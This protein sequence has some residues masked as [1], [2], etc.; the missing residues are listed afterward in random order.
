MNDLAWKDGMN[1]SATNV[2]RGSE[3]AIM[4]PSEEETAPI[5][6]RVLLAEWANNNDEWIRLLVSEAITTGRPVDARVIEKVYQL[7]RQEK[8]LDNR[9]LP[10]VPK[11]S[12]QGHRDESAL[13]LILTKLSNV[14]GVN[15]LSVGAVIEPHEGLTI[16]YGE[17][18]TGK[19]GYARIFKALANSRTADTILGNIDADIVEAQSASLEFKLGNDTQSLTWNGER[20]ISPFTRMSIFDS[21]AVR[22]HV[23]ED[24]EYMY[25]PASLA[26]FDDVIDG[27]KA[28]LLKIDDAIT[29]LDTSVSGL[30]TRFHQG[31]SIYPLI[32]TL[33]PSTDLADLKSKIKA[34]KDDKDELESLTQKVAL[35]R[36]NTMTKHVT[37]LK[38]ENHVLEQALSAANKI[39]AFD[40][41][42]Y[43]DALVKH[44]QLMVDYETFRS[45]LF[46][47]VDLPAEPDDTWHKFVQA[48]ETY[49]QHLVS[50]EAE[51]AD[52]CLYCRQPLLDSARDLLK[53]YST[54]LEDKISE[55]IRLVEAAIKQ[56]EGQIGGI[57]SNEMSVYI[58][59]HENAGETDRPS[60]FKYIETIERTHCIINSAVTARKPIDKEFTDLM[61]LSKESIENALES[62]R[63]K[64]TDMEEEQ[65][66]H[67][68][69]LE[70]NSKELLELQDAV[71]LGKSWVSIE[72]QVNRSKEAN[73]LRNL[74]GSFRG[75]TGAVT[76]LAKKASDQLINQNFDALFVEE[77]KALRAPTLKVQF[78]GREGKAH[79]RKILSG[80]HKPSKILSE[81]EQ[82]VLALADF[83][84]EARLAGIAAP[85]VFDDPVSSLDHRRVK[86]VAERI[87]RLAGENQVIVFTHDILF[88][89][90]LLNLFEK[91]KRCA[92][93]HITDE[94]GKG[95]VTRG[96]GPRWDTLSFLGGKIN[97]SIQEARRQSGEARD[98]RVRVGYGWLR[99]WCEVFTET[100]LL[101]GVTQRYQ[102]NVGMTRLSKIKIDKLGKIIPK[103]T[104]VFEEACRYIDS[105][106]QPLPSLGVR[107]TLTDLEQHWSELQ[108]L[109]RYY[110]AK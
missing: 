34:G 48:A 51:D 18:G 32:E 23:D 26:F 52:H 24:L 71:E 70:G 104:E 47:T 15:A 93:F 87:A 35:L 4:L 85:V 19:T 9:E 109:K 40:Q 60:F 101:Q 27:I 62:T 95:K 29:E 79:R 61:L 69:S 21:P 17:N 6:P 110:N 68:K 72:T 37:W 57:Q 38:R 108:E 65:R 43:N 86:E 25:T 99:S 28:V 67:S 59:E 45:E 50:L 66:N 44:A 106:S 53:R 91:S 39:L 30:V 83:L 1:D 63:K 97:S 89:T 75:L 22:I 105:H 77:C 103:V 20:G 64:L 98:E 74:K 11:L 94:N 41:G 5:D 14:H 92:Y 42:A 82:K 7:L 3:G 78:I 55:E 16:F 102:P 36:S 90:T 10:T 54:Y 107:P 2:E 73:L 13:P 84:A 12:L 100:E 31:S 46:A 33:G 88:A 76:R 80:Q 8:S 81:G 96:T 56:Y 49:R 58:K